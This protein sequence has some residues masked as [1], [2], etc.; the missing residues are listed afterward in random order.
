MAL[1]LLAPQLAA[2]APQPLHPPKR[3]GEHKAGPAWRVPPR[4]EDNPWARQGIPARFGFG[5]CYTRKNY[6]GEEWDLVSRTDE[7]ADLVVRFDDG[8]RQVL[9]GRA[10]SYLP[11]VLDGERVVGRFAELVK[12]SGDGPAGRPDKVNRFARARLIESTPER[13]VVHYRYL[14]VMPAGVDRLNPPDQTTFVDEYFVFGPDRTGVR[15][16]RPGS[17]RIEE[18]RD[19][20]RVQVSRF[21][22]D[23]AGAVIVGTADAADR[24]MLLETMGFADPYGRPAA[25]APPFDQPTDGPRPALAWSFDE[26]HGRQVAESVAGGASQVEGHSLIRRRGV[27]GRALMFDG[28]TTR[29]T[30]PAGETPDLGDQVTLE[31][32][33]AIA[34]Y[35]WNLC[36]VVQRGDALTGGA[37][38]ALGIGPHGR[39]L[40]AARIGGE[41]LLLHADA[42][43]FRIPRFRWTHLAGVIDTAA[44]RAT[45]YLDG[46]AVATTPLPDGGIDYDADDALQIGHGP[47]MEAAWPVGRTYGPYPYTFEGLIDEV[48]VYQAALGAGQVRA[49]SRAAALDE[50]ARGAPDMARRVLPAGGGELAGFGAHYTH[51]R[52]HEAWDGMFRMSGHPDVVV[53]FDKMPGRY[54]FWHGTGYIPMMVTG[55]GHWYSNEFNE[56]WWNGCCE[57][58]S[59]K[60][61]VFGRVHVLEQSPARVVVKWRYPL[62]HVS[63]QIF[64][65]GWAD[66]TGWGEWCDWY[67]TI[68]PD[69]S[70]VKRMRSWMSIPHGREW[71]ESMVIFG[72]EQR[73]EQVLETR[74]ALSVATLGGEVRTYDWIDAPPEEVDYRDVVLH[75]VNMKGELDPYSICR[76]NR[77]N[78]YKKRGGSPYSVFPAWN[79]WP[80]GQ[81]PSDGR[82]VRYPDRT[83]HSSATHL[84]WDNSV[85]FG[86]G[87]SFEEKLLLEGLSAAPAA[88]LLDTARSYLEPPAA[89]AEGGG[90]TVAF[91]PATRA[92]SI[93]RNSGATRA[94]T[95]RLAASAERPAV[96]P[97]FTVENWGADAPATITIDGG[98][99]QGLDIRQG[100]VPR[101]NGVNALVI[102]VEKTCRKPTTFGITMP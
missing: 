52:F 21:R 9:F 14:P 29:V 75:L 83:A 74:P 17:P 102:W 31:G 33:V 65:E 20:E 95:V 44:R 85:E 23:E 8:S 32:W 48:R 86:S 26:E 89:G 43:E 3:A 38:V 53:T 82:Y 25:A 93:V 60:R 57:P 13:V 79:H 59:D 87:G 42:E 16:M 6:Q 19:A 1:A 18:W 24:R 71:H 100:V 49:R 72:P 40:L 10:T 81:F 47:P 67:F 84:Y 80:V 50:T 63:Y 99:P 35:P 12:R 51:L 46:K 2:G 97:V 76:V 39:P 64:G 58:M 90:F 45:V 41:Q 22:I 78:V 37:G 69:G 15:G 7:F 36:P 34:A 62:S 56:T 92:Y 54:V 11:Q 30:R 4:P 66:D 68:Y 77:G 94:M 101:A 96:N 28:Y 27:A 98:P 61:V 73:P 91:D 70:C 88:E 55:N 5:A